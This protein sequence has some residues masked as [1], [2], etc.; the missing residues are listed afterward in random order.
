MQAA[1]TISRPFGTS[2]HR[3]ITDHEGRFVLDGLPDEP[4]NLVVRGLNKGA[5]FLR[6]P[7]GRDVA[8]RLEE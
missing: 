1:A 7:P 5:A 8:V 6:A 3:A 4:V 2:R